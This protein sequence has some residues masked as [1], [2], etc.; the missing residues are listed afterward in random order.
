M[1]KIFW[2]S[3][4]YILCSLIYL[5]A[6]LTF[7]KGMLIIVKKVSINKDYILF[8]RV[9]LFSSILLYFFSI[10][11]CYQNK[12]FGELTFETY[13]INFFKTIQ[14]FYG[15]VLPYWVLILFLFSGLVTVLYSFLRN[16]SLENKRNSK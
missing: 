7:H 6:I 10:N 5:L 16:K 4:I 14:Y 13:R 12:G 2:F 8:S 9:F 15:G 11:E 1:E 3:L